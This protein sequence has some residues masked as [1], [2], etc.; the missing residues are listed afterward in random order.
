MV[1]MQMLRQ[2]IQKC[3]CLED[4]SL[5]VYN[6]FKNEHVILDPWYLILEWSLI[7]A[8]KHAEHSGDARNS[9][10]ENPKFLLT[11]NNSHI[12]RLVG[13]AYARLQ[14]ECAVRVGEG[15][16]TVGRSVPVLRSVEDEIPKPPRNYMS[17]LACS[18]IEESRCGTG[19]AFRPGGGEQFAYASLSFAWK[20][21]ARKL[22]CKTIL[23][24]KISEQKEVS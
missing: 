16:K 2:I 22:F 13:C 18:E 19:E 1:F 14:P 10:M 7:F 3:W 8:E 15:C 12:K 21:S 17:S 4:P 9:F 5:K 20:S 24:K 11:K 23:Y 6:L